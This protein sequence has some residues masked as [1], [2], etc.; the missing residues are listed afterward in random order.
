MGQLKEN[1]ELWDLYTLKHEKDNPKRDQ[2][3]RP[4]AEFYNKDF[5]K[6]H[7]SKFLH[8]QGFRPSYPNEAKFAVCLTHDIDV[9]E[10]PKK[11]LYINAVKHLLKGRFPEFRSTIK[12]ILNVR[13]NDFFHFDELM[14]IEKRYNG[15]ATYYFKSLKKGDQDFNYLVSS[16]SDIIQTIDKAGFEVSLHGGH[17][18][19]KDLKILK[20]EKENLE[21]TLGKETLGYRNH[22]LRFRI[23]ETLEHLISVGITSDSTIAYPDQIGFRNGMCYPYQPYHLEKEEYMDILEVP[24]NIMECT[25]YKYMALPKD[26]WMP[27]ASELID[28]VADLN[29]V[30]NFLWHN[31][32]VVSKVEFYEEVIK[33]CYDKGAWITSVA[34]LEKWWRANYLVEMK[35]YL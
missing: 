7:V 30:F 16:I 34:E 19:Y 10:I 8:D 33:Y 3:E 6:A 26:Q 13:V 2:Y 25:L 4:L 35:K 17:E 20:W 14:E 11:D 18:A 5:S 27:K 31:N 9:L 15:S 23:P 28:H 32:D 24:L 21:R 29:G 1:K 22:Y 12:N